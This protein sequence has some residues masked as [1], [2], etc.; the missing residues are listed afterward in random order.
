MRW[1]NSPRAR[2][3]AMLA[4]TSAGGHP[5]TAVAGIAV[6]GDGGIVFGTTRTSCKFTSLSRQPWVAL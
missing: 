1:F 2:G 5:Q 6:T 4:T 3:L